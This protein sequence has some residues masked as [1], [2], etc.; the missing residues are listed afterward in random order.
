MHV[1]YDEN[2][3]VIPH[4][5]HDEHGHTH[6]NENLALLAYMLEHNTHHAAELEEMA[7][8]MEQAGCTETAK[9]ILAGVAE[10]QKGNHHLS[11]A[12]ESAEKE[13]HKK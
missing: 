2:G 1:L 3:N 13:L 7:A 12:L 4:G 6:K 10:F 9:E 8:K 5:E 11:H